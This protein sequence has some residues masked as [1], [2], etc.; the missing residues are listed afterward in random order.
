MK[1]T[2]TLTVLICGNKRRAVALRKFI[3]RQNAEVI[4]SLPTT[5]PHLNLFI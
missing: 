5:G 3:R 1:L 2:L 4:Y